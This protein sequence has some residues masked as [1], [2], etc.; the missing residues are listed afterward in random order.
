MSVT[1]VAGQFRRYHRWTQRQIESLKLRS[2]QMDDS[3]PSRSFFGQSEQPV[4]RLPRGAGEAAEYIFWIPTSR[5]YQPHR[6]FK[7]PPTLSWDVVVA[8]LLRGQE[9]RGHLRRLPTHPADISR[10]EDRQQH[11]VKSCP[12]VVHLRLC[13]RHVFP[14]SHIL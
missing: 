9:P 1:R 7:T 10:R 13:F 3:I 2:N 4:W 14:F 12:S 5:P 11:Q 8:P 6:K